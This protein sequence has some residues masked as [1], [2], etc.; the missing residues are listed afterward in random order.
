MCGLSRIEVKSSGPRKLRKH[1]LVMGVGF[2]RMMAV[3][4]MER[5]TNAVSRRQ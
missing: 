2:I 5:K 4:Q 1:G 3:I